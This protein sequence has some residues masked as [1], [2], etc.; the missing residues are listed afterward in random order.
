M[1][2]NKKVKIAISLK[3]FFFAGKKGREAKMIIKGRRGM[4]YLAKRTLE[5][6]MRR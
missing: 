3:R 5:K 2:I 6:L 1:E 4:R